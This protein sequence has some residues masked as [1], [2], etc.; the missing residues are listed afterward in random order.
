MSYA[1]AVQ[2]VKVTWV[3]EWPGFL[4]ASFGPQRDVCKGPAGPSAGK[5]PSGR[6]FLLLYYYYFFLK[7]HLKFEECE[8]KANGSRHPAF[9]WGLP[10][11]RGCLAS[12]KLS[13]SHSVARLCPILCYSMDCSTPGFPVYHWLR[14]PAQTHVGDA[15]GLVMP[16]NH[17]ILCCPLL[18][19]PSILPS[20]RDFSNESALHIMWPKYQLQHQSFQWIFR[21]DFL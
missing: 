1:Q 4:Y 17:L 3:C 2:G 10:W 6:G 8:L 5:T 7:R 19:L 18:L 21:V 16:S 14:K 15:I 20:I 9:V 12:S 13:F 11:V